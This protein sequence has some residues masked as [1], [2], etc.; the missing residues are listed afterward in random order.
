MNLSHVKRTFH[1]WKQSHLK[2]RA[3]SISALR[4]GEAESR[5]KSFN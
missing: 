3:E 1:I 4:D 2:Y 5:Y